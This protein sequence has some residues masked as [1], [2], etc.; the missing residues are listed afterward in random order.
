MRHFIYILFLI[1]FFVTSCSTDEISETERTRSEFI[2]SIGGKISDLQWWHTSVSL[3]VDVTT[4]DSVKLLLFGIQGNRRVLYDYKIVDTSGVVSMT[5]PQG[6]V[7]TVYLRSI[8]NQKSK[9]QSI[10]LSGKPEETVSVNTT[11]TQA[12]LTRA[13]EKPASLCGQSINKDAHYISLTDD[14]I[15]SFF[16]LMATKKSGVDAKKVDGLICNYEVESNGPFFITWVSGYEA[17]QKSHI[18]GYY[19]HSAVSYDD[20]T[21]VDLSETHKWDYIDGLSKVQYQ[22]NIED[23]I[24]GHYF[25]PYTWY[26]ANFDMSDLYGATICNNMDRVGDNAYNMHGVYKRYGIGISAMRGISFKI[27]VP[28]G[29]R[30]GFYLRCDEEPLPE[31]WTMLR[32]NG[33]RPYTENQDEFM[34]TNFS[35]EFMNIIGKGNG[36]HRSFIK[37]SGDI[38]WMGMEDVLDGGDLDCDDVIF[39]VTTDLSIHMPIIVDPILQSDSLDDYDPFPWT[40]AYEDVNRK[41]DY[42]FNDAVIKLVPDYKNEQ[43]CVTVMAAGSDAR[44]YLHYDGPDG[45]VN[46]GEIHELLGSSHQTYINTREGIAVT[47]F[48]LIDCVP[49]PQGYTM[50]N[51]AKR[52]YIEIQ[53]GTCDDCTDVITLAQEPGKAPEAIL[54][55]G[56][57]Q[58]PK[59]GIHIK[60]AYS[61]FP[62]WAGDVTKTQIWDWYQYPE[63]DT[64]VSYE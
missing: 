64:Y 7:K 27:D 15:E 50:A 13:D 22:I 48:T 5:I 60:D 36:K 31:Q 43:C 57:W 37:D 17:S 63:T 47:P 35:A 26:D 10:T 12:A 49:W 38:Y 39:G 28:E 32:M 53:R 3:K 58:W 9:F 34:G 46:L 21:Y 4:E 59:E 6:Q 51:D 16:T 23:S 14:Q 56:E 18:L 44:M 30:V 42:D 11:V 33:I 19:Y 1:V 8:C 29:V 62:G 41:A 61:D 24:D 54:V 55:A 25:M 45:D 40:I 20:I 52:F 2:D